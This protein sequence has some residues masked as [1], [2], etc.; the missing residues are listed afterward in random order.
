MAL[1]GGEPDPP[2]PPPVYNPALMEATDM[3]LS[4]PELPE[5]TETWRKPATFH[6]DFYRADQDEVER[7]VTMADSVHFI[8]HPHLEDD[9]HDFFLGPGKISEELSQGTLGFSNKLGSLNDSPYLESGL[10][11]LV[12]GFIETDWPPDAPG[13]PHFTY[14]LTTVHVKTGRPCDIGNA[15]LDFLTTQVLS[16]NIKVRTPSETKL[17]KCSIKADVFSGNLVCTIKIRMYKNPDPEPQRKTAAVFAAEV[18]QFFHSQLPTEQTTFAVEFS[19]RSGDIVAFNSTFQQAVRFL[20]ARMGVDALLL[21]IVPSAPASL[22]CASFVAPD[23]AEEAEDCAG[24]PL[25]LDLLDERLAPGPDEVAPL[26]DMAGLDD[27]PAL[28]VEAATALAELAKN[29]Q[30][31]ACLCTE[32][33]FDAFKQLLG[34]A[35]DSEA[36]ITSTAVEYYTA[37]ALER[38]A[39]L[40]VAHPFFA[41]PGEHGILRI[42]LKKV[43]SKKLDP[44]MQRELAKILSI[45]V[46][47]CKDLLDGATREALRAGLRGAVSGKGSTSEGAFAKAQEVAVGRELREAL[48]ALGA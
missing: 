20:K 8:G 36:R 23:F 16:C 10:I 30:A 47:R 43:Q 21:S 34:G 5:D 42:I 1:R 31:A 48:F 29:S 22:G 39:E 18:H 37:S 26:L 6:G 40:D 38:L 3:M 41:E 19:R 4:M 2:L 33:A 44:R 24:R 17:Q 12:N 14:E 13:D 25:L 15:L 46:P 45:A 35:D 7:G 28:Q 32:S 11:P 27:L 9:A